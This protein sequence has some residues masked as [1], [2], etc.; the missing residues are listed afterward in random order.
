MSVS[1]KF[2]AQGRLE[3]PLLRLWALR[4]TIFPTA[5]HK[6]IKRTE[7]YKSILL[8]R[9]SCKRK[10]ISKVPAAVVNTLSPYKVLNGCFV[11]HNLKTTFFR[12]YYRAGYFVCFR[13]EEGNHGFFV[14][15]YHLLSGLCLSLILSSCCLSHVA[16]LLWSGCSLRGKMSVP[17]LPRGT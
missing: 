8:P 1:K 15:G 5:H 17:S 14:L 11:N 6:D 7:N 16:A 2:D 9:T 12:H 3:L 10:M 13:I 4:V